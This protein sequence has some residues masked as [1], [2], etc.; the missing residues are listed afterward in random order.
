MPKAGPM[1]SVWGSLLISGH[2]QCSPPLAGKQ[3]YISAGETWWLTRK[4]S[5][6]CS[7]LWSQFGFLWQQILLYQTA[8][9][10]EK[11]ADWKTVP[12]TALVLGKINV[13]KYSAAFAF[14]FSD[15]SFMSQRHSL[16][17]GFRLQEILPRNC[18]KKSTLDSRFMSQNNNKI[19]QE[20]YIPVEDFAEKRMPH[21]FFWSRKILKVRESQTV[22][23][24]SLSPSVSLSFSFRKRERGTLPFITLLWHTRQHAT[25]INELQNEKKV[26]MNDKSGQ[27][28]IID[29]CATQSNML[30][31]TSQLISD[32]VSYVMTTA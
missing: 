26:V 14:M 29:K 11:I 2:S 1:M 9:S 21:E 28:G 8:N 27:H 24:L 32:T 6:E 31:P 5:F 25:R 19:F 18:W 13:D 23:S 15:V 4:P 10:T 22:L 30:C 3:S 7:F 16:N 20:M 12:R 17:L